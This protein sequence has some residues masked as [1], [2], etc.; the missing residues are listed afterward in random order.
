L[1]TQ[2]GDSGTGL[3][4]E[5][6]FIITCS[7][8]IEVDSLDFLTLMDY[9]PP[10]KE[11]A[12]RRSL[13]VGLVAV[14]L[15]GL[16]LSLSH[17]A[18]AWGHQAPTYVNVSCKVEPADSCGRVVVQL[19]E[20]S[21]DRGVGRCIGKQENYYQWGPGT[22]SFYFGK[23]DQSKGF[24]VDEG[25]TSTFP[26]ARFRCFFPPRWVW[27]KRVLRVWFNPS[28]GEFGCNEGGCFCIELKDPLPNC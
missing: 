5:Q 10:R 7:I 26:Y 18:G 9:N 3:D 2:R 13:A 23:L 16:A 6:G 27:W 28:K 21:G 24:V 11:V 14:L 1:Q 22:L 17:E 19:Y 12:V 20:R 25:G 8:Q 15:V 4:I